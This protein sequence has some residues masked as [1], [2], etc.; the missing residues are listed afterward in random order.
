MVPNLE[1]LDVRFRGPGVRSEGQVVLQRLESGDTLEVIHL[2]PDIDPSSLNDPLAGD[3]ELVV[4][5]AA[6]WIVMRAPVSEEALLELLERL[7]GNAS[8][9]D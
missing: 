9:R 2:P 5:R 1:V 8:A 7:L 3:T 4:Q 6:G